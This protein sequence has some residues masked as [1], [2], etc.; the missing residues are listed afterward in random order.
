MD[1]RVLVVEDSPEL[2]GYLVTLLQG[3]GF[4]V[5][6]AADGL[7]AMNTL[8]QNP[9]GLVILDLFMPRKDG[10]ETLPQLR[11]LSPRPMILAVS[12][13]GRF[14]AP[15]TLL[16]AS[17]LGADTALAKPFTPA[18]LL[19]AVRQLL[20]RAPVVSPLAAN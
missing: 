4:E 8:Q 3:A 15:D 10:F 17:R 5:F 16:V 7:E 13:G 12:G 11:A 19:G 1:S 18:E 14:S 9:C 6:E 20:D 2:R